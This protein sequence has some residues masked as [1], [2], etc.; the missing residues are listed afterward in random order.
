[1]KHPVA[2]RTRDLSKRF[3]DRYAIRGVSLEVRRG[4]VFG[5]LG[6]NGAGKTTTVRL[7][8]GF[9]RPT[10]GSALVGG[11]DPTRNPTAV[12]KVIG[13]L[14]EAF[15]LYEELTARELLD[16]S[17]KLQGMEE[18]VREARIHEVLKRFGLWERVDSPVG[19]YSKGMRQ[20]LGLARAVL[21]RPAI[22]FLDEPTSGLD[23][24]AAREVRTLVEE[25]RGGG[26]T[27]FLTTH[28][29]SEAERVC[30]SVG[31]LKRGELV[32][33]GSTADLMRG[34]PDAETLE[35]LY[36]SVIPSA[37]VSA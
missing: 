37:E 15:G 9:L 18:A 10:S 14:P 11:Y 5:F 28:I 25:L 2:I 1:M 35:D 7:L 3:E 26:Q 12:R 33:S 8:L 24:E 34:A 16:Y 6:P 20:K 21:N 29:L 22:L 32:L 36:F 4:E 31:F 17:G 23:P 27:I 19:S 13:Y 30:D